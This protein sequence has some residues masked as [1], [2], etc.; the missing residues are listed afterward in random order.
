MSENIDK[1]QS[2]REPNSSQSRNNNGTIGVVGSSDK[3]P[4]GSFHKMTERLADPE[5]ANDKGIK[6]NEENHYIG[7]HFEADSDASYTANEVDPNKS[8]KQNPE[9]KE[10]LDPEKGY[11]P[12]DNAGGTSEEDLE[13]NGR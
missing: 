8:G 1:N 5:P 13:K 2:E 11:N 4:K 6:E 10:T 3:G 9:S 7:N 12:L